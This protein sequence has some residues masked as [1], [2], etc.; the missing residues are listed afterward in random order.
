MKDDL[1]YIEYMLECIARIERYTR[2]G[3]E[4]FFSDSMIADAVIRNLQT[5]AESSQRTSP[6]L[7][8][9]APEINWRQLAG[10]RNV[11]VHDYLGLELGAVWDVVATDLPVL[12]RQLE[13][14]RERLGS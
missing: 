7:K 6:R 4:A 8:E 5:L 9:S 11:V 1:F 3:M 2:G 14:L 10:F 12:R 13:R